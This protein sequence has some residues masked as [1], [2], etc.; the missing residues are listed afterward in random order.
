VKKEEHE[1]MIASVARAIGSDLC[2]Q[3]AFV[4]GCTTS[5]FV[6]DAFALEQ[7]RH[8][9]DV[10]LIIN[11][12]GKMSWYSLQDTLRSLGFRDMPIGE[13][14][15]ICAMKYRDL[16]VDFMPTDE[17]ILGFT[18]IWYSEALK[19]SIKYKLSTGDVINIVKPEYFVATKL[20]AYESRGKNDPLMS[21][22]IEDILKVVDGR[23]EL[24]DEIL[25]CPKE[26]KCY[27]AKKLELFSAH[28]DWDYAVL[29]SCDN[30]HNREKAVN[31]KISL[32]IS[33][34]DTY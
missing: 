12:T 6:T 11:I 1:S 30:D 28:R 13:E 31:S 26:L 25:N 7:V 32:L 19:N 18:N 33:Y 14:A 34:K 29:N 20:A 3:V 21:Q 16:R 22:D 4:G 9:E 27:I 24:L 2:N 17:E 8:T 5:L 23:R 10:D 15:P